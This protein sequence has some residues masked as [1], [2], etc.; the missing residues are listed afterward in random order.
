MKIERNL[1]TT[2]D[3]TPSKLHVRI[4]IIISAS[5]GGIFGLC[6]GGSVISFIEFLYY[7]MS[8]LLTARKE[9]RESRN[10]NL[11]PASKLFVPGPVNKDSK[12]ADKCVFY[13]WN[14][15]FPRQNQKTTFGL[16]KDGFRPFRE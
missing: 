4:A 2:K 15:Q 9:K 6:L 14:E 10:E 16:R 7:L 11:P 13:V 3:V 1:K 5:F 8:E 12:E